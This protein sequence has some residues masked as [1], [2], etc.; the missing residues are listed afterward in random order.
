MENIYLNLLLLLIIIYGLSKNCQLIEKFH[1][2]NSLD[3]FKPV[4]N[5][6]GGKY[7]ESIKLLTYFQNFCQ[8]E[9]VDYFLIFGT[10]LGQVRNSGLIPWDDDIDLMV[11]NDSFINIYKKLNN[12]EFEIIKYGKYYKLFLRKNPKIRN[13]AWSWPFID[14]FVYKKG[15]NTCRLKDLN[16]DIVH[17]IDD[18]YPLRKVRFEN[19]YSH[20]PNNAKKVLFKKYGEDCLDT[21]ISSDYNHRIENR[22][23]S[24]STFPCHRVKKYLDQI[25]Y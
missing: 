6:K 12:S 8:R 5:K 17:H 18:I 20:I 21:C 3:D 15:T 16:N 23:S 19:L 11:D 10:L 2:Y 4:W 9:G 13:Y 24:Q 14:I 1:Q 7:K 22:T 25:N